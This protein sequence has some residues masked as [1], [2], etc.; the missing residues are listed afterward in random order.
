MNITGIKQ[1]ELATSFSDFRGHYH[2]L[3]NKRMLNENGITDD[4]IQFCVSVSNKLVLRGIH[5]DAGTAKL[6]TCL[7]GKIQYAFVDNRPDSETYKNVVHGVMDSAKPFLIYLPPGIGNSYLTLSDVSF[8]MYS[9]TTYYGDFKQFTL[10]WDDPEF[11]IPWM[12]DKPVL[13]PRDGG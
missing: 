11:K 4:F 8:Y 2:E 7:H 1:L 3:F 5:G 12:T 9:Q 10:Q 13:S 6:I